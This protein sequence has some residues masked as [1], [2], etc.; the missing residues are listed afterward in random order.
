MRRP[1]PK[2]WRRFHPRAALT[3]ALAE[4][5]ESGARTRTAT[6]QRPR[7]PHYVGETLEAQGHRRCGPCCDAYR[8]RTRRDPDRSHPARDLPRRL[9]TGCGL[10]SGAWPREAGTRSR[11]SAGCAPQTG[12]RAL[13]QRWQQLFALVLSRP[14]L[15]G[16]DTA[17]PVQSRSK[18][19]TRSWANGHGI[20]RA[21][22]GL[23]PKKLSSDTANGPGHVEAF[24]SR[25]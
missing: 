22:Q 2:R 8:A 3:K 1:G 14:L 16:L 21:S 9:P 19:A 6:A 11:H 24:L 18:P 7:R 20:M 15:H 17:P 10:R 25:E 5:F 4:E 12:P 13:L 23:E